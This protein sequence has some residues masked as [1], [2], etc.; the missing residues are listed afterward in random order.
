MIGILLMIVTVICATCVWP[1][2]RWVARNEGRSVHFGFWTVLFGTLI[3]GV[4]CLVLHQSIFQPLLWK[5]AAVVSVAYVV[6]YFLIILYCLRIGP[7]GPT[8]VMNNMGGL[9]W[10]VVVSI[11]VLKLHPVSARI[12]LGLALVVASLIGFGFSSPG[13]KDQ[14]AQNV[15]TLRWMIWAFFGWLFAGVSMTGQM[16]GAHYIPQGSFAVIFSFAALSIVL[17]APLTLRSG[18]HNLS[19]KEAIPG[20]VNGVLLAG[21]GGTTQ[22]ALHYL[23][24]ELVF[25]FTVAGPI[26]L[27]LILGRF[28]YH[29][30]LSRIAFFACLL[31]ITGLLLL[32]LGQR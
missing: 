26:V 27:V 10:P 4:L 8:T 7:V 23:P 15:I 5:I 9:I 32:T 17:L 14:P 1:V 11:F 24:A 13:K 19:R 29:E 2:G 31:S 25:P 22:L 30:R 12:Y 6:G 3:S 21:T 16:L 18:V 20:L 28:F